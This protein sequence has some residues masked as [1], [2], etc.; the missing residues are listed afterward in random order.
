MAGAAQLSKGAVREQ[1]L[2]AGQ[3]RTLVGG[4]HRLALENTSAA[5]SMA[6]RAH[7]T[8]VRLHLRSGHSTGAEE[9]QDS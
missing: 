3:R 2:R 8:I 7:C 6:D 9:G 5:R 4:I 1:L